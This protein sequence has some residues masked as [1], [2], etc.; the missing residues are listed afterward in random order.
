[1]RPNELPAGMVTV[2]GRRAASG[3]ELEMEMAVPPAGAAAVSR[4]YTG[5]L[6]PPPM[7]VLEAHTIAIV[8]PAVAWLTTGTEA[9]AATGFTTSD[10]LT[11]FPAKLAEI[12]TVVGVETE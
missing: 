4:T 1:M 5:T 8:G 10:A 6:P 2:E 3:S 12:T 7:L 11:V 9:G